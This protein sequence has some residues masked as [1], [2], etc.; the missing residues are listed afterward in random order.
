MA[1]KPKK[2][3][4]IKCSNIIF[5]TDPQE[6]QPIIELTEEQRELL[7]ISLKNPVC[8]SKRTLRIINSILLD[9]KF[10][11]FEEDLIKYRTK[12]IT[13]LISQC[14]HALKITMQFL[15]LPYIYWSKNI[16]VFQ[17]TE[18][19]EGRVFLYKMIGD[20]NRHLWGIASG[21]IKVD[22]AKKA[23]RSYEIARKIGSEMNK[24]HPYVMS[25]MLNLSIFID[26]VFHEKKKALVR[27]NK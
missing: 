14:K 23:I 11:Y 9:S 16:L 13:E 15:R 21:D 6:S 7:A 17:S 27:I 3:K 4:P 18:C 25:L 5:S 22:A 10:K 24:A 2:R 20:F 19:L 1:K 12:I 8:Q 26:E